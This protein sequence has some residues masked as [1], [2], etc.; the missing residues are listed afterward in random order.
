MRTRILCLCFVCWCFVLSYTGC[1]TWD[2]PGEAQVL[3]VPRLAPD[4]VVLEVEFVRVPTARTDEFIGLWSEVDE[5]QIPLDVRRRLDANGIR[6]G[7]VGLQLPV[8]LRD[9]LD[10]E[11]PAYEQL[12]EGDLVP[13]S[14]IFSNYQRL[15]CRSG[16]RK[17]VVASP[18]MPGT[19]VIILKLDG[20]LRAE[21]YDAAQAVFTVATYPQGDGRVRV[22]VTPMI[23]HGQP[24]MKFV[25][26]PG[27]IAMQTGRE[28]TEFDQMKIE[29]L[30][31]P[32]QTLIVAGATD[33]K[34]LG[35]FVFHDSIGSNQRSMM[36]L[37]LA[38]S[39]YDDLWS[40]E[41]T[42]SPLTTRIE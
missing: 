18:Q 2:A 17:R 20:R 23:E 24:Q 4:G 9:L 37:R 39:Q 27:S 6:S 19:S 32:G 38:Q 15:Q 29:T 36:L 12:S 14:D 35:G 10:A 34:G 25:A 21:P 8:F 42:L 40:E 5:Q 30:L 13:D 26:L 16:S 1:A 31:S 28:K 22:V 7:V 11:K 41:R 33:A 3:P